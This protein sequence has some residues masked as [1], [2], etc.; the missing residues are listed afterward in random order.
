MLPLWPIDLIW[1]NVLLIFIFY[2][3]TDVCHRL[4]LHHNCV[5]ECVCVCPYSNKWR[6]RTKSLE[7]CLSLNWHLHTGRII[8]FYFPYCLSVICVNVS[9]RQRQFTALRS[10]LMLLP[11]SYKLYGI[12]GVAYF[13]GKLITLLLKQRYTK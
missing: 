13:L 7:L 12:C 5:W 1:S 11:S 2:G 9:R 4:D 8:N 6:F 3:R 10:H